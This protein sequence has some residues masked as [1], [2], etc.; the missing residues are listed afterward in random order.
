MSLKDVRVAAVARLT[1]LLPNYTELYNV[2]DIEDNDPRSLRKGFLVSWGAGLEAEGP[3]RK[4]ALNS[5]L[6]VTLT[7]SVETR[8]KDNV[9]PMVDELYEDVETVI[10]SFLNAT[11]LGI[12]DKIR[13]IRDATVSA[14][15]LISGKKFVSIDI[16]FT[17]DHTIDITC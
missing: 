7:N 3:T 12:P 17:V 5:S 13:G 10:G 15:I 2:F 4:Y 11:F 6:I 8:S 14:P 1:T 9:A 16:D